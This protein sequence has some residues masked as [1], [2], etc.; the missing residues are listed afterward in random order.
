MKTAMILLTLTAIAIVA[1]AGMFLLPKAVAPYEASAL[2]LIDSNPPH[3]VVRTE[4]T[5]D[6]LRVPC[7]CSGPARRPA[8]PPQGQRRRAWR[9]SLAHWH[10]PG[11]RRRPWPPA[12]AVRSDRD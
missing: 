10:S 5:P 11:P 12:P 7:A 2:L 6:R 8:L 9:R 4:E 3:I 1:V